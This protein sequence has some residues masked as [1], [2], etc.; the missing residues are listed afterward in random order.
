MPL[1]WRR[2]LPALLAL[3]TLLLASLSNA[4]SAATATAAAKALVA[5][6]ANFK[7]TADVLAARFEATSGHE[8]VLVSGATGKLYTQIRNGAP[9]D[10]FLAADTERPQLLASSGDSPAAPRTYASGRLGL[11]VRGAHPNPDDPAGSLT[12]LRRVAIANPSLAPYGVAA[13]AVIDQLALREH[14]EGR[15]AYGENVAQAYAL[16]AAGA[17]E[18]GLIAWSLLNEGGRSAESWPVPTAWHPAIDQDAVL[19]NHGAEN[20]AAVAFF[21]YLYSP[22]AREIIRERGYV[23]PER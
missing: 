21:D 20:P 13:M 23:V 9:F 7:N 8:V 15:L 16:I 19:L 11:W 17:A 22:A 12:G 10:L 3:L 18:G 5:V 2:L 14:M 1:P 6:A 4:A